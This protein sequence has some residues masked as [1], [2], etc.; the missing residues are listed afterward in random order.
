MKMTAA[1]LLLIP[2]TGL[3]LP[4][5]HAANQSIQATAFFYSGLIVGNEQAIDFNAIQASGQ[6][7]AGDRVSMGS[8]GTIIYS[9]IFSGSGSG[10]AGSI[11]ILAGSNGQVVE[12]F[13][14]PTALLSNGAGG[15]ITAVIEVSP[16]N[17]LGSYGTGQPCNGVSGAPSG[18]LILGVGSLD[19][20]K[21]GGQI[22]GSTATSFTTGSYSTD[23]AGGDN[24]QIN[25][26]YQ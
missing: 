12:V 21:F 5:A 1:L 8:N 19:T 14:D 4:A 2:I 22:N 10:T 11:D 16:E 15:T 26:L 6:P 3:A 20:F 13:C 7:G 18:A 25:L 17:N 24:V 9:G 23:N